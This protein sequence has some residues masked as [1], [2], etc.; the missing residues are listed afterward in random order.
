MR[1][2]T[3]A[4]PGYERSALT[5]PV[6]RIAG[7]ATGAG[8]AVVGTG[9]LIVDEGP[10]W[11]PF[12][13]VLFLAAAIGG[14]LVYSASVHTRVANGVLEIHAGRRGARVPV[15]SIGYV[16]RARIGT[17]PA[18]R[19]GRT[20]LANARAGEGVE[21][22]GRD[23][24]YVTARTDT[25][26]ELVRALLAEGLDP[27]ALRVPFPSALVGDGRARGVRREDRTGDHG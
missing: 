2:R 26:G 23:G 17:R 9:V 21:I 22:V 11:W 12:L 13:A 19:W 27:A 25:P 6:R 10:F 7:L 18:W 4:A 20:H 15:A 3:T 5:H 14:T 1:D 8:I 24:R 16:G